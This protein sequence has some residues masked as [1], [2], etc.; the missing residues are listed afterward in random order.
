[1]KKNITIKIL[2][3]FA[4]IV[5]VPTIVSAQGLVQCGKTSADPCD[6]YD[7]INLIQRVINFLIFTVAMPLAAVSFAWA[8]VLMLT[9]GGNEQKI[10]EARSIFWWVFVGILVALSAWLIIKA[11]T[12]SLLVS[13]Y[14][15]L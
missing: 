9:A 3:I 1:M 2:I 6:F 7:F 4:V 11:I 12:G 5:F 8:G 13:G 15:Y 14:S 10:S